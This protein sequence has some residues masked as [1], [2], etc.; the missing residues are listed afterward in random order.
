MVV[1]CFID[2]IEPPDK[3]LRIQDIQITDQL[4]P[5]LVASVHSIINQH[6]SILKLKVTTRRVRGKP[7]FGVYGDHTQIQKRLDYGTNKPEQVLSAIHRWL[8]QIATAGAPMHVDESVGQ[9]AVHNDPVFLAA[10]FLDAHPELT[11]LSVVV[12]DGVIVMSA[13]HEGTL[14]TIERCYTSWKLA[15][16]DLI[17]WIDKL[18][19]SNT[20][21]VAPVGDH[22]LRGY[23]VRQSAPG[24][25][26][27]CIRPKALG[28]IAGPGRPRATRPSL[29]QQM[30][31]TLQ[32]KCKKLE[33]KLASLQTTNARLATRCE[34]LAAQAANGRLPI[35]CRTADAEGAKATNMFSETVGIGYSD[36]EMSRTVFNHVNSVMDLVHKLVKDDAVKAVQLADR[37]QQRARGISVAP[38]FDDKYIGVCVAVFES[39]KDFLGDLSSRYKTKAPNDVRHIM[40]T[41]VTA[42]MSH[43]D[44][45]SQRY[46]A[47]KLELDRSWLAAGK[48]RAMS[49][50]EEGLLDSIAE[51][52]EAEHSQR[53]PNIWRQHCHDHWLAKC[54]AGEKMRDK[55]RNPK[56]QSDEELYTIHYRETTIKDLYKDC[57]EQG[58]AKWPPKEAS[59]DDFD[60]ASPEDY[61]EHVRIQ[62][63]FKLSERIYRDHKPFQIRMASRDQCMC[64]W[65]LRFEYLAEALHNF[66]KARREANSIK[67]NCP[68]LKTGTALRRHLM[69]PRPDDAT[70]DKI[71]CVRQ[72]CR[73]CKDLKRLQI[74]DQC[75]ASFKG[76]TIPYQIYGKREFVKRKGRAAVDPD[77]TLYESRQA[78]TVDSKPDFVLVETPYEEFAD[79][80]SEYWEIYIAHHDLSKHQDSDWEYQR[81]LFPPGTF[82]STQDYSENYHHEAKKEYQSAYFVEIGSTV[83]G[84]VIRVHLSDIGTEAE[85]QARGMDPVVTDAERVELVALF[86]RIGEPAILTISHI[87]MSSDLTHD[88]AMVQHCNDKILIPWMEKIKATG[89]R[90]LRHHARSD[91]CKAQFKCGTQFLWISSNF[92]RHG[93]HLE[94][95]FFCR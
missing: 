6:P 27:D 78:G 22:G 48:A 45:S 16:S 57:V 83:Y 20:T 37:V 51:T 94:W 74:C 61:F 33:D 77:F 66:W 39:I 81:T 59:I 71:E 34:R 18:E 84:M 68:H 19:S 9:P 29:K 87:V 8:D 25:Y 4:P 65:H 58:E 12:V 2:S 1:S 36:K 32:T 7:G 44:A 55:L 46:L 80:L 56:D 43:F 5:N 60:G 23:Q 95:N 62:K 67:C 24:S 31:D 47:E 79:Y 50:Y 17:R 41:I 15:R 28:R 73:H 64:I 76:H 89:V 52:H 86:E 14:Y 63:G 82:V 30:C 40:Q 91:G 35:L 49:F 69:C 13:T 38:E 53:I 72:A 90:W 21:A 70:T 54:R 92:E 93:M 11:E 85:L 3:R 26:R 75:L 42:I 10:D 88:A